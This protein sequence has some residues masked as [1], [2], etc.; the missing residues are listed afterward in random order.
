MP[1]NNAI[2]SL[3]PIQIALG[4]TA[5]ASFTPYAVICGGTTATDPLQSIASV[6]TSGQVLTSNDTGFLPTFQTASTTS[7]IFQLVSADPG[8]PVDGQVW[9]NETTDLFKGR[10][11]G[12]TVTFTVT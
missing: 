9:Y 7:M 5:S 8:S 11:N 6:G 3:L 10:A 12:I 2:N 1:T 4:G